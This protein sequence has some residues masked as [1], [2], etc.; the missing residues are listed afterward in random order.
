M[1]NTFVRECADVIGAQIFNCNADLPIE[2]VC[3]DSRQVKQGNLFVAI[4]GEKFDGAEFANHA[5]ENGAVVVL[6]ERPLGNL[7]TIVCPK[8]SID[9]LQALATWYRRQLVGATVIGITGSAGKTLTKDMIA[10][11]LRSAGEVVAT[12]GSANNE[13]GLPVTLLSADQQTDFL[14]LEM[15]ARHRGDIATLCKIA[16]PDIGVVTNV[17]L[18]HVEIFGSIDDT[19]QAKSEIIQNLRTDSWAVLN[20]DDDRVTSMKD[21]TLAH[22][23]TFG[24]QDLADVKFSEVQVDKNGCT[25]CK[26]SSKWRKNGSTQGEASK[27][28]QEGNVTLDLGGK[29]LAS[30]AAAA[31]AVGLIAD[32]G[33]AQGCA[34]LSDMSLVSPHRARVINQ[35]PVVVIDDTYNANPESMAAALHLLYDTAGARRKVAVLGEMR[36]LGLHAETEHKKIGQQAGELG[37]SALIAVG[38]QAK[39]YL[40]SSSPEM[41]KVEVSDATGALSALES[42]LMPNDVVLVKA[43]RALGLEQVVAGLLSD[44]SQVRA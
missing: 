14:V 7:P 31:I 41:I 36:E 28:A 11:V 1:I 30:N 8:S 13:I 10:A 12:T 16:E 44:A 9:A 2:G 4:K 40:D 32:V 38:P 35:G 23:V 37:I 5:V 27:P 18:A 6:A 25:K 3:T 39:F 33:V 29:H 34:A 17:G 42:M 43:S 22:V 21:K 20:I 24:S 26:I 15:G 19:A